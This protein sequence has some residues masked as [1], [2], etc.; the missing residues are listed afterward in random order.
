M[1][2]IKNGKKLTVWAY[3]NLLNS[4]K[5][6]VLPAHGAEFDPCDLMLAWLLCWLQAKLY[7]A[8]R[9][10]RSDKH[11]HIELCCTCERHIVRPVYTM[12]LGNHVILHLENFNHRLADSDWV[13]FTLL[14]ICAV[15]K[16]RAL[17]CLHSCLT[18]LNCC[19]VR[20]ENQICSS[21][22]DDHTLCLQGDELYHF[23]VLR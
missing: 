10:I 21:D 8:I 11:A 14:L 7:D 6:L 19:Y 3:L 1:T 18:V 15:T 9:L 2:C 4:S 13:Y 17:M 5:L 23:K 20:E 12:Y 22:Y 16:E